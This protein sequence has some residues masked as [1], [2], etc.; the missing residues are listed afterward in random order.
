MAGE[1][2]ISYPTGNT[3]YA[4]VLDATGQ[5]YNTVGASFEAIN[6][7][8]WTQYDHALTES[9]STGLY[10]GNFP[11]VS[12]GSFWFDIRLQAGGSRRGD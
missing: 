2:S 6:G 8:N 1:L 9:G 5:I 12:A 11:S 3:L 10:I 4:V 7:S